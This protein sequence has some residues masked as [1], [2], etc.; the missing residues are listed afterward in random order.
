MSDRCPCDSGLDRAACC[1]RFHEGAVAPTA[2]DLMRS[3]YAAYVLADEAYLL[4]TWAPEHRPDAIEFDPDQNWE[5]LEVLATTGGSMFDTEGTVTFA[6]RF[7][8][9]GVTRRLRE[10][11]R[12]RRDAGRWL[13]VDADEADVAPV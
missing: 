2:L 6:A 4:G 1:A 11:S 8:T 10:R 7:S 12:F 5:G 9:G 13:Y 3:R